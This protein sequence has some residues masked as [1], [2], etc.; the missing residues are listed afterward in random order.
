MTPVLFA[1]I[2]WMRWYRGP[3]P[4][5]EKPIGGGGYNKASVGHEAFNFLPLDDRMLG[6]FQ[7]RLQPAAN[8]KKHPSTIALDRITA[9]S[10]GETL[11]GVLVIF[12]AT[13]PTLHGQRIVGW[14]DDATVHRHT[15]PSKD[16]RRDSFSYFIEAPAG[17]VVLLPEERREFKVPS[18]E[19]GFGRANVCYALKSNGQPKA[20]T[21]WINEAVEYVNSYE[22]ENAAQEPG[23]EMDATVADAI[24]ITIDHAAGFQSNP[25]IRKAIERYAMDWAERRL[26]KLGYNPQDK[27]K[28]KP[29]DF[30]CKVKGADL[31][32]EVKGTQ[33]TGR[34]VSLTPNEAEH[35][36]KYKNSALFIVHSVK[37]KGK[38]KPVVSGGQ[39]LL[40]HPWDISSGTLKPRSY[41]F[42][43]GN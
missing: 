37:V 33:D 4:D 8:R 25:R 27:H 36:K 7:P 20:S 1:R 5:D 19:G 6:Y 39:E 16:K 29:Y 14:F 9:K 32:V 11:G 35:A 30:L 28:T 38:R 26:R 2:G 15:Q 34:S 42:T 24:A 23:S 17:N 18:G 13:D 41:I 40:L 12:V 10:V 3:Q 31:F 21:Q 43:L 22:L